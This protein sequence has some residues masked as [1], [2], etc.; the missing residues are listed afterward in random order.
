MIEGEAPGV[1]SDAQWEFAPAA[2]LSITVNRIAM[3]RKLKAYLMLSS[4]LGVDLHQPI[5]RRRLYDAI[6]ESGFLRT[7][8]MTFDAD[9]SPSA[10]VLYDVVGPFAVRR[11]GPPLD[12]GPISFLD[13]AAAELLA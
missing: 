3:A 8:R 9:H 10:F 6:G 5:L 13:G 2:I 7:R 4:G 1:Q 11:L 12:D